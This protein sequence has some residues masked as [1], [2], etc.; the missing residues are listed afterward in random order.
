MRNRRDNKE[1]QKNQQTLNVQEWAAETKIWLEEQMGGDRWMPKQN[2]Q[3]QGEHVTAVHIPS[4][5]T[6]ERQKY[7]WHIGN[8][9][10]NWTSNGRLRWHYHL[11]LFEDGVI[12]YQYVL[13]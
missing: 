13:L 10:S 3:L 8:A 4:S 5:I 1:K 6:E 12:G 9:P 7:R 11:P 2:G